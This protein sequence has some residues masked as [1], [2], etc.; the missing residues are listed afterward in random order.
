M[1]KYNVGNIFGFSCIEC[2]HNRH[3]YGG[4]LGNQYR[5]CQKSIEKLERFDK[6]E[7]ENQSLKKQVED[8]F[9]EN[10]KL[11]KKMENSMTFQDYEY[12]LK[13]KI[14][15]E[16]RQK[17]LKEWL[18]NEIEICKLCMEEIKKNRKCHGIF[19]VIYYISQS[20]MEEAIKILSK[21]KKEDEVD[22]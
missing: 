6:L 2:E 16:N 7:E 20:R 8:L 3:C 12:T 21:L 15:F 1:N 22:G 10:S 18:E 9:S 17:G 11:R 5:F 4:D 19:P 13:K 14:Q